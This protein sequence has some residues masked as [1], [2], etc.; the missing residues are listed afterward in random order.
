[1]CTVILGYQLSDDT[2]ILLGAN[3][4]ERL[5]R[6][7]EGF[8]L[9]ER[10]GVRQLSPRDLKAGGTWIGINQY[11]VI[12]AI[13]NRFQPAPDPTRRTRGELVDRA[14]AFKSSIDA[15]EA[16]GALKPDDY[17]GFHLLMLD[18]KSAHI[19]W[20]DGGN[21]HK[22]RLQP[23]LTVLT[24]RSFGAAPNL[25]QERVL[26]R[27]QAL[28]RR[29]DLGPG[30]LAEVLSERGD[31]SIDQVSVQLP[32]MNYGTRSSS[33]IRLGEAPIFWQSDQ[34]P[35]PTNYTDETQL[36]SELLA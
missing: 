15:A 11:G 29:G 14:L 35:T 24:E 3:R 12:A 13:T 22:E 6:T 5:D 20:N 25:R 19:V 36:L 4:D 33:I 9:R 32:E 2:P 26:T 8:K 31:G 27:C 10:A 23:G 34:A 17:N 28:C 7:A 1:M 21:L 18:K 30:A 16:I